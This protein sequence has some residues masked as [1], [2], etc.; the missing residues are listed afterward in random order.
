MKEA[1]VPSRYRFSKQMVNTLGRE[2][3]NTGLT[4][5]RILELAFAHYMTLKA[6]HRFKLN[7]ML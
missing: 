4:R 5:T 3:K 1:K 2:S 7:A 6:D